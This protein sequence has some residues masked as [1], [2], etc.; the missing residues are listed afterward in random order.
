MER[1]SAPAATYV[2]NS[3][4][5]T[6]AKLRRDELLLGILGLF[7]RLRA[8]FVIGAGILQILVKKEPVQ[9]VRYVVVMRHIVFGAL[10]VVDFAARRLEEAHARW[11]GPGF[12]AMAPK[13][14]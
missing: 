6:K 14:L 5:R 7:K 8:G 13:V 1:Q 12:E 10:S 4:A 3:E 11:R 9:F 2:Q